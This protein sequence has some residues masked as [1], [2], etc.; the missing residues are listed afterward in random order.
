VVNMIRYA[1]DKTVV[2]NSQHGL[3][4]LMNNLNRV[5]RELSM[6]INT[7]KTKVK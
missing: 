7:R 5:T 2:C 3:Q 1:D 4:E 6:R